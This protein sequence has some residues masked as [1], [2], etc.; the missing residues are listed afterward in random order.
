MFSNRRVT[1][2]SC[3]LATIIFLLFTSC[4]ISGNDEFTETYTFDANRQSEILSD[5][6]SRQVGPDSI[7]TVYNFSI[8]AGSNLVFEYGRDVH[9]PENVQD[10]GLSETLVFQIPTGSNTFNLSGNLLSDAKVFYRRGCFCPESG[11][12]FKA[13]EGF[14]EGERLSAN[15]WFVRAEVTISGYRQDYQLKFEHTFRITN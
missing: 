11:A 2:A 3:I 12:G 9:P 8:E 14:I 5:T 15:L 6:T 13:T 1:F 7:I 4:N 10:G